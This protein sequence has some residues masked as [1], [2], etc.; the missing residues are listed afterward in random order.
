MGLL[1]RTLATTGPGTGG[2]E[3]AHRH[4]RR[5]AVAAV[6]RGPIRHPRK[7]R[8]RRGPASHRVTACR[9]RTGRRIC[10]PLRRRRC[11]L[12]TPQRLSQRRL[13]RIRVRRLPLSL[14][15]WTGRTAMAPSRSQGPRAARAAGMAVSLPTRRHVRPT[16]PAGGP[17]SPRLRL[18]RWLTSGGAWTGCLTATHPRRITTT[19]SASRH[20][21]DSS[22]SNSLRRRLSGSATGRRSRAGQVRTML[23][24]Q[25]GRF[26]QANRRQEMIPLQASPNG[27]PPRHDLPAPHRFA[28]DGHLRPSPRRARRVL[29]CLMGRRAVANRHR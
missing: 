26:R 10:R 24:G 12:L 7:R 11:G 15:G 28:A 16:N 1:S 20:R 18:D 19:V 14:R 29:P 3:M 2:Q 25:P 4:V 27:N 17:I 5:V 13:L 22:T 8:S 23:I 9:T 21:P 6:S